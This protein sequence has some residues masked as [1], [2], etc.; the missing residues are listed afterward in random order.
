MMIL[1]SGQFY[2]VSLCKAKSSIQL[3][4]IL[5][6]STA[7]SAKNR[8]ELLKFFQTTLEQIRK[9]FM[10]AATK[11]TLYVDCPYCPDFHIKYA[12]L[13]KGGVQM[14]KTVT[15]PQNYYQDLFKNIQGKQIVTCSITINN[16]NITSVGVSVTEQLRGKHIRLVHCMENFYIV[17]CMNVF[18]SCTF[19]YVCISTKSTTR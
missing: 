15:I 10:A 12:N 13:L 19:M 7:V 17:S 9:E 18:T 6:K 11:P 16:F 14:C 8:K 2:C 5:D 1:S 4:I 3:D